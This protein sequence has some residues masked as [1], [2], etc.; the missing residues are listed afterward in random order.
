M[1]NRL[2]LPFASTAQRQSATLLQREL[3]YDI[4]EDVLY[5]GDGA[6]VGGVP[7]IAAVS[8][9]IGQTGS[10]TA[11]QIAAALNALT[12]ADRLDYDALQNTPAPEPLVYTITLPEPEA[13]TTYPIDIAF[14]FA[15]KRLTKATYKTIA[16]TATFTVKI[17][18]VD[19]TSLASLTAG[20]TIA[21]TN[22]TAAN[23]ITTNGILDIAVSTVST[24]DTLM[25]NLYFEDI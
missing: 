20:T 1:P 9:V 13:A 22:A 10:I 14:G 5:Y 23:T 15:N 21:T 17:N 16:G 12:L 6:T 8:S 7:L 25:V 4:E 11:A 24:P 3:L 2:R 19:V 18:N